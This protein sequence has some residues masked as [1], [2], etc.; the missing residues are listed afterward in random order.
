MSHIHIHSLTAISKLLI[1]PTT[2]C[3]RSLM[4]S[5]SLQLTRAPKSHKT[6]ISSNQS[7]SFFSRTGAMA[8]SECVWASK[9]HK[10]LYS[11]PK[12]LVDWNQHSRN[13]FRENTP[14]NHK[15]ARAGKSEKT[16]KSNPRKTIPKTN[17]RISEI[18]RTGKSEKIYQINSAKKSAKIKRPK[19]NNARVPTSEKNRFRKL[20]GTWGQNSTKITESA[21]NL[22]KIPTLK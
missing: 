18:P 6:R 1:F 16:V 14:E 2:L 22:A 17:S 21:K 8:S 13:P 12:L 15:F 10:M 4:K 11:S 9:L 20:H 3:P 7:G 19:I 5:S